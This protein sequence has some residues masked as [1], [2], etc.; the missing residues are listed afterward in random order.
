MK[1][2]D[3][4]AE[5]LFNKIRGRF[6]SVT[7]GDAEGKVTNKPNEARFFDFDFKEA[8]VNL[9]KVSVSLNEES[10]EV[11]YSDNFVAEQDEITKEKWYNF[12]KELRQFSKKRLMTFD[13]RNINK[14]NLD[15]R[16]YQFLAQNRGDNTMAESK[17]YG[18]NKISY[19][20]VDNAK[21]V[22][23]HTESV[24]KEIANGRIR[25]IG[26]IYIEN[27]DGERFLYPYKHLTGARAMARHVA[28]GGKPFDDFG[29]HIIGLSEE[30]SKLRK[31]KSYMGRSTVMAESLKDYMPVVLDRITSVKKTIESL[32]K[33]AYYT[34]AFESYVKPI[35][36][37]VPNDVAENWIDQL[38]IKQF[39]EELKDVFPYI[40]NL[41]S[42]ATK[43]KNLGPEDVAEGG[44]MDYIK[45]KVADFKQGQQDRMKDYE[46]DLHILRTVL[47]S[48]GYDD[49][50]IKKVESGCLNDPRVC[51][52][53]LIRKNN[54]DTGDMDVEVNRIGKELNSGFMTRA[55]TVD[56]QNIEDAFESLMGQFAEETL[57]EK[58][59]VG[60]Q[61]Y[62][63]KDCGCQMHESKPDCDCKHDCHD[64][65]GSW[66]R[67]KNGNGVPDGLERGMNE[68]KKDDEK[69]EPHMMYDPKTGKGKMAKVE[70][71]HKDLAAKGWTHEK[72]KNKKANEG[73]QKKNCG[74][75]QDPCITYGV[76]EGN[77]FT[78]A[79]KIA[80][81]QDDDEMD[82]DGKKIPVTEFVLSLFDRE[83][84]QFPKGETAV[85]TAIEKDYGEEYINP[86]KSF[87]ERIM[88]TYEQYATPQEPVLTDE[89]PTGTVMEP[90]V[91]QD[92]EMEESGLQYYTGVKK[93]GEEYMK[94]AAQAG[95]DGASQEELGRLK[96]KY[97]KAEKNKTTKEAQDIMR[98]AG[99]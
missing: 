9:G 84:G 1:N 65:S 36:E 3:L 83:T 28:E 29:T 59:M 15:R 11:M 99:L 94:K 49:A 41:V 44:I 79:L 81:D 76:K 7:I 57:Q 73:K 27:A 96:D 60:Y 56:E 66:W 21:I 37:D 95:R 16:D 23:K 47:G 4:I 13:T 80:R 92:E 40:Y 17:L 63:C 31:F 70:K 68:D 39:N 8:E 78:K 88:A 93:H 19:Q 58:Y 20:K 72:P 51:L 82:V 18:S 90:T 10:I 24:N 26:K 69:F 38:T 53:N 75:G 77:K 22:I 25:N 50:T 35:I 2:L 61:K 67:D 55:G 74:C 5:E 14:S 30:L 45:G 12:L 34:K 46:Q 32:Q 52:Y 85:L 33:P 54:A 64:E 89:Q 62:H 91:A 6:P 42:E 86:A 71:D 43:A 97:S 48:H 87:I 98:L